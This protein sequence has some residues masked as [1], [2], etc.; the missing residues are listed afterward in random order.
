[1]AS[2]NKSHEQMKIKNFLH[3]NVMHINIY[4]IYHYKDIDIHDSIE[5]YFNTREPLKNTNGEIVE[6]RDTLQD[7]KAKNPWLYHDRYEQLVQSLDIKI[8]INNDFD[9]VIRLRK[10]QQ[11]TENQETDAVELIPTVY[12]FESG[13]YNIQENV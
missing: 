1:M 10:K 4:G 8:D 7:F 12:F 11:E 6:H 3:F 9:V 5:H 2:Q 13:K